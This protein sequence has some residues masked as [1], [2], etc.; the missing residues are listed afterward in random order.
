M[1]FGR[2]NELH[3]CQG[4]QAD[5][6]DGRFCG[7]PG[8]FSVKTLDQDVFEMLESRGQFPTFL[9]DFIYYTLRQGVAEESTAQDPNVIQMKKRARVAHPFAASDE[10]A[11]ALYVSDREIKDVDNLER[12]QNREMHMIDRIQDAEHS[13]QQQIDHIDQVL[14]SFQNKA[15]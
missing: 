10:E 5:V 3:E 7:D 11:L 2:K 12:E 8:F 4:V 1:I 14:A 6:G 9:N 15:K 13:L